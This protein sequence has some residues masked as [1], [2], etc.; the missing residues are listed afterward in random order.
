MRIYLK[1]NPD[2]FHPDP[3]SRNDGTR[4]YWS[5]SLQQEKQQDEQRYGTSYWSKNVMKICPYF[6]TFS[7]NHCDILHVYFY[8]KLYSHRICS[9]HVASIELDP[10]QPVPAHQKNADSQ[11]TKVC[12]RMQPNIHKNA[13]NVEVN[14]SRHFSSLISQL[15]VAGRLVYCQDDCWFQ[16]R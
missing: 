15:L 11:N 3:I 2:K 12:H 1:N 6:R 9:K 7:H 13:N 5:G 16:W 8:D 4:L 14:N 10:C